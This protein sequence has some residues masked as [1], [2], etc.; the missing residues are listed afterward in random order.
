MFK[1]NYY[2]SVIHKVIL[3]NLQDYLIACRFHLISENYINLKGAA[4]KSG[5]SLS[6]LTGVKRPHIM[7]KS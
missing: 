1:L 6:L 3:I 5:E 4:E 7:R 2:T